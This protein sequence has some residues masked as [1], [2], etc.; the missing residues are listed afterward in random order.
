MQE[1]IQDF[2]GPVKI[3][4]SRGSTNKRK[5]NNAERYYASIFREQG[6]PYCRTS[7]EAS[8]L[9]DDCAVDLVFLPVLVQIKAGRQRNMNPSKVLFDIT[10]RVKL[11]FP[12]DSPERNMPSVMIHYK[13][14]GRGKKRSEYDELVTMTFDT[15]LKFLK[16]F[17]DDL[18]NKKKLN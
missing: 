10:E 14:A 13:E 15:F 18:Q 16:T 4:K 5:G 8:K 9:H 11:N 6:Y 17:N 7:R 12:E 3:K 1:T 2:Q